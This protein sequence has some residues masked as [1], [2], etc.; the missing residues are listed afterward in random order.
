M[1]Y[2]KFNNII[3]QEP[4]SGSL[5]GDMPKEQV[6]QGETNFIFEPSVENIMEF[7]ESQIFSML[8]DQ[9]IS[10]G[11]LARFA[12]RIKAMES[13]QNNLQKQLDILA[14]K[15]RRLRGMEINKKQIQLFA[16]Q[17]LWGKK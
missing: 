14:S 2:G 10:E 16:G 3:T 1:T 12:S 13:A 15:Q 17:S 6:K 4:T 5:T 11:K 9:T 8:L 7:F